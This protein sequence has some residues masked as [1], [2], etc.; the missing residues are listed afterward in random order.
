[1]DERTDDVLLLLC[2]GEGQP[3]VISRPHLAHG[4]FG[5]PGM[6]T[7]P[8]SVGVTT[9]SVVYLHSLHHRWRFSTQRPP[10]CRIPASGR[11]SVNDLAN[12]AANPPPSSPWSGFE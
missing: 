2:G 12:P 8:V 3:C 10:A 11:A 5:K 9:R 4:P 1:M 6:H 7:Q